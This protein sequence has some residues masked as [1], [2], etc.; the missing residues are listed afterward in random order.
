MPS[1]FSETSRGG[2]NE[3][4]GKVTR[5]SDPL[6]LSLPDSVMTLDI[7]LSDR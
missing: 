1:G 4:Q 6:D 3:T 2:P 5:L 7:A